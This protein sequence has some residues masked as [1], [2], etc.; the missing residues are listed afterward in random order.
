MVFSRISLIIFF[1][2]LIGPAIVHIISLVIT[3]ISILQRKCYLY[4]DNNIKFSTF[5]QICS[6]ERGFVVSP[7]CVIICLILSVI[8]IQLCLLVFFN[9]VFFLPQINVFVV[10]ILPSKNIMKKFKTQ[11]ICG[12]WLM[13]FT[14]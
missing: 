14:S 9:I 12:Q 6:S 8:S 10:Q 1:F 3:C 11:S 13:K 7:L 2:H 5:M 4:N